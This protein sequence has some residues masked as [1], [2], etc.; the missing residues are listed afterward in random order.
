MENI[1]HVTNCK[2][3]K[4]QKMGEEKQISVDPSGYQD[5]D[6]LTA[7]TAGHSLFLVSFSPFELMYLVLLTRLYEGDGW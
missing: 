6:F 1:E 7:Y 2:A 4:L 3:Y 5:D